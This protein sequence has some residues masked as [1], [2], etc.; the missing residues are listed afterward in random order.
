MIK[1]KEDSGF[2]FAKM[3]SEVNGFTRTVVGEQ[4]GVTSFFDTASK[5]VEE[6][7]PDSRFMTGDLDWCNK[8]FCHRCREK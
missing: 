8:W 3:S 4:K 1:T 7:A 6:N 2:L 5:Q